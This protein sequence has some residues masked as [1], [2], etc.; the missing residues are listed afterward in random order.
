[1]KRSKVRKKPKRLM[2]LSSK[3]GRSKLMKNSFQTR[4]NKS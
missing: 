3:S 1:M 4:S 2:K